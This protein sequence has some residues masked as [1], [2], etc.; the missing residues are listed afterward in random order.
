MLQARRRLVSIV[1]HVLDS[2]QDAPSSIKWADDFNGA[3][4]PTDPAENVM[5]QVRSGKLPEDLTGVYMRVGPNSPFWPPRKRQHVFDGDGMVHSVRVA[6][7]SATY[8]CRYLETPRYKF[9]R[10]WGEEWFTR[11][12]EFH[13]KAGLAKILAVSGSK[14]KLAGIEDWESS[15]ANTA[16]VYHPSGKLWALNEAGAPFRFR[17]DESGKP[18]SIGYDT[19]HDTHRKPMSAHP[20]IDQRTGEVFFHGREIMKSFYAAREVDGKISECVDLEMPTGFHHDLAITENFVLI[21]DGSMRFNTRGIV[22]GKPLWNFNPKQK[23]RFGVFRRGSGPMTT[24]AFVWIEAPVAAELVHVLYSYDEG[25]KI[26]LWAPLGGH[27]HGKEDGILGGQGP[28]MMHRVVIDVDT[29]SVD[30]QRVSERVTEFPRIRDDRIGLRTRYGFSGVQSPG[31]DFNFTG[32]L[33]WDFEE[34]R[35]AGEIHYPEGVVGGE[36]VFLPRASG[37]S[38]VCDDDDGY[39][40]MFLWNPKA[41]ESTWVLYD[42]RSF[43]SCPVVELLVPRRVPLG[44]HAAWLTEEQFQKQLVTV[45]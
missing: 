36:P 21:I 19:L 38:D 7:G 28:L 39:I 27:Q 29:L 32:I 12:G 4:R 37:S 25:G 41:E 24:E 8:H 34:C 22:Q 43:S 16:I 35:L 1:D 14:N 40:A 20:K 33:K 5:L 26:F 10:E 31:P 45:N 13:G 6:N 30:I 9:E 18:E 17:L 2:M 3:L 15:V 11:I 42:A 44:F 23:L